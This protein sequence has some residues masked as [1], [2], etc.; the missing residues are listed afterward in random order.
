M[1]NPQVIVSPYYPGVTR[2]GIMGRVAGALGRG[3]PVPEERRES[4]ERRKEK[5]KDAG[6]PR[7]QEV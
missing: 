1:T 5:R 4:S 7:F 6:G 3:W 2:H